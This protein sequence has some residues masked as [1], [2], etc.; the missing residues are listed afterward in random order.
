VLLTVKVQK[1]MQ[2]AQSAD[3]EELERMQ[4]LGMAGKGKDVTFTG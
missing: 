3:Q 1:G 2:D 4:G